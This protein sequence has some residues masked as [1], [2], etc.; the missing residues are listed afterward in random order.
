MYELS[1]DIREQD[2]KIN[3]GHHMAAEYVHPLSLCTDVVTNCCVE[4]KFPKIY[5]SFEI[6]K[7][8]QTSEQSESNFK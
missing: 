7:K 4:R 5:K 8:W 1:E 6:L 3:V 2:G